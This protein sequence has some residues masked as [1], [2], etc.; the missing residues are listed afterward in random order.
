MKNISRF[1]SLTLIICV[2]L[3][4]F[5]VFAE[6]KPPLLDRYIYPS[7]YLGEPLKREDI[8]NC[9]YN[10]IDGKYM[11]Y[12]TLASRPTATFVAYN[13][14]DR[15]VEYSKSLEIASGYY[16][17]T[18]WSH[19][20]GA[21]G[22]IYLVPHGYISLFKY[23]PY[24]KEMSDSGSVIDGLTAA[25]GVC[26]DEEGNTYFGGFPKPNIYKFNSKLELVKEYPNV[27]PGEKYIMSMGCYGGKLYAGGQDNGT[28]FRSV[29]IKTGE[30][31][32]MPDPLEKYGIEGKIAAYYMMDQIDNLLFCTVKLEAG[33]YYLFIFDAEKEEWVF[34]YR[35]AY[36]HYMSPV[37]DGK[38]YF[39]AEPP[40]ATDASVDNIG[41]VSLDL[42]TFETKDT[43]VKYYGNNT[44]SIWMN[45]PG[46]AD[47]PGESLVFFSRSHNS[48]IAL[49]LETK[50]SVLLDYDLPSVGVTIQDMENGLGNRILM[51][52]YMG[53]ELVSYNPD[54]GEQ[55]KYV[56]TQ[57]E[58]IKL[59]GD[60]AYAGCYTQGVLYEY[61]L[62]EEPSASNPKVLSNLSKY[63]QERIFD[64]CIAE[65]RYIVMGT[66]PNKGYTDGGIAIYDKETGKLDFYDDVVPGQSIDALCY[67]D[68]I[69]YGGSCIYINASPLPCDEAYVFAFDLEKREVIKKTAVKI[70][71]SSIKNK[72]MGD[73]EI[74]PDG[75]IWGV[76]TGAIFC[77]D[78]ETL[79]TKKSVIADTM[80]DS[81]RTMSKIAAMYWDENGYLYTV[82]NGWL[83]LLDPDTM[84]FINT[85]VSMQYFV[86]GGD[87]NIYYNGWS[88]NGSMMYKLT[89]SAL[90]KSE[91]NN[92]KGAVSEGLFMKSGS[93]AVINSGEPGF[94]DINN[95]EITPIIHNGHIMV[96]LRYV[97]EALG[98]TVAWSD[99]AQAAV[100]R[101]GKLA[102]K[103]VIGESEICVN[104]KKS[105]VN[106]PFMNIGGKTYIEAAAFC[107]A[108]GRNFYEGPDGFFAITPAG[109]PFVCEG[110]LLHDVLTYFNE[111]VPSLASGNF[112][113][114]IW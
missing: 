61:N 79:E 64:M 34:S 57:T 22:C 26:F 13:L 20:I 65:D 111:D 6:E 29:D 80:Y 2:L 41:L 10:V 48:L 33:M 36:G 110:E 4:V 81:R 47:L 84:E 1:I 42:K 44:G 67:K 100:V 56:A 74:G 38:V 108:F 66:Y 21:D 17:K 78:P 82:C 5:S 46:N 106:V 86:I 103:A 69:I 24:T 93:G 51:G 101:I 14:T 35:R 16:T 27:F 90:T 52:S 88:T 3:S 97:G 72:V 71:G 68:G 40:G 98:G 112:Y 58:T 7:T 39:I 89:V 109:S 18:S 49:N 70:P 105:P 37:R 92:V 43:G 104:G 8:L 53:D 9:A 114:N 95:K 25:Y 91:L 99:K 54:N 30:I 28:D 85:R 12:T 60:Y 63:H 113:S 96:P 87:G 45:I 15:R 32:V 23:N 102:M 19:R 55:V 94:I 73:M 50:K 31:T 107:N 77:L 75:N 83:I 59:H 11:M 62:K 76:T